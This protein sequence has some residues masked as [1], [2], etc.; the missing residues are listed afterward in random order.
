MADW[1]E[2]LPEL[3]QGIA[4]CV[5]ST[6]GGGGEGYMNMRVVCSSW[7]SAISKPSPLAAI[8]DLR[9]RPRHWV[10]LNLP[11]KYEDGDDDDACLFFHVLTG[12]FRCL[13]LPLIHDHILIGASDGLLVLGDRDQ[14][15]HLA[16]VLNPL[17]GDMLP[18][19]AP[20]HQR[21]DD[22]MSTAVSG[23]SHTMLFSWASETVVCASPTSDVLREVD[24][25][26]SMNSMITFQGNVYYSDQDGW[27]FK[28]VAPCEEKTVVVGKMSPDKYIHFERKGSTCSELVESCG[29]LL[30]VHGWDQTLNVFRVNIKHKLLEEVN[31][32]GSHR[33][34]F[35]GDER[36]ISVDVGNLPSVDGDCVYLFNWVENSKYM[37]VYNLRDDKME[38]IS[39][40][41]HLDRPYSL[42]QV[43]LMYCDF[44]C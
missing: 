23:G 34:L 19:P 8:A 26:T 29:E 10:M 41:H 31:S 21:F 15:P 39:S 30:L 35:L 42:V 1:A 32:L 27:V 28:I 5:L 9:F 44:R 24:V 3:V 36:C 6:T 16:R 25:G 20:V 11:S 14:S 13:R 17:T 2:L 22:I 37:C 4:D 18:F 12:R 43:L 33:A 38:V 40:M 7:R